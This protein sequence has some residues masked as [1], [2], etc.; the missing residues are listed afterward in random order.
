MTEDQDTWFDGTEAVEDVIGKARLLPSDHK[1]WRIAFDEEDVPEHGGQ[2]CLW[3][4][5]ESEAKIIAKLKDVVE[6]WKK[7]TY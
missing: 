4:S 6:V 7:Q 3:F 2:I 1:V 5:G